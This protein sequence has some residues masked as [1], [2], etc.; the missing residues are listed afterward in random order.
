LVLLPQLGE[1]SW[2]RV[3]IIGIAEL[4]TEAI[5]IFVESEVVEVQLPLGRDEPGRLTEL[6]D[7]NGDK[8]TRRDDDQHSLEI[9]VH[10]LPPIE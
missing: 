3:R 10:G 9:F 7:R 4:I 8:R 1:S 6:V 5:R 2:N